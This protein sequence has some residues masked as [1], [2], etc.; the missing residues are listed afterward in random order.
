MELK[1]I[2]SKNEFN[3]NLALKKF[4]NDGWSV[5]RGCYQKIIKG[6]RYYYV[7]IFSINTY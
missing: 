4:I 6:Q 5:A 2:K 7:D 3:M 1:T